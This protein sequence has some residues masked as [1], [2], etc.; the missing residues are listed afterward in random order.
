MSLRLIA[1]A[2]IGAAV[3]VTV[4]PVV[5]QPPPKPGMATRMKSWFRNPFKKK[6]GD[7][8]SLSET[9][10]GFVRTR[11]S[12]T[13][14]P[15]SQP[16]GGHPANRMQSSIHPGNGPIPQAGTAYRDANGNLKSMPRSSGYDRAMARTGETPHR[17]ESTGRD[18]TAS[19]ALPPGDRS[20][21]ADSGYARPASHREP[22]RRTSSENAGYARRDDE[23][24]R[25]NTASG[26]AQLA[27]RGYGR[28]DAE[29]MRT[30]SYGG[31]SNRDFEAGRDGYRDEH[32]PRRQEFPAERRQE[33]PAESYAR[34][35]DAGNPL[36]RYAG[37]SAPPAR[38]SDAAPRTSDYDFAPPQQAMVPD[39]YSF[40]AEPGIE[41]DPTAAGFRQAGY[42]RPESAPR[43][44]TGFDYPPSES[45][46]VQPEGKAAD[47]QS[48][49]F[50]RDPSRD[51][52]R[53]LH[54]HRDTSFD[55]SSSARSSSARS[56]F[57][58]SSG[59]PE[60]RPSGDAAP[61]TED[62]W[63]RYEA[64]RYRRSSDFDHGAGETD[65]A[66]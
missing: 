48:M 46:S 52:S 35:S 55:R 45:A 29:P 26:R 4:D 41:P 28:E 44:A 11:V 53:P 25:R 59:R 34:D 16:P 14:S 3:L 21:R 2:V 58:R 15:Y 24:A 7:Y 9:E 38:E 8:T 42:D 23:F 43:R 50:S 65:R 17:Q 20:G 12:K 56:S 63:G 6:D 40:R 32:D 47:S 30:P 64:S 39:E 60:R 49:Y 37:R 62:D 61:A 33:T 1:W 10:N 66:R 19:R 22:P 27:G 51:A 5:A 36:E 18:N 57:D 31:P 54:D 13:P